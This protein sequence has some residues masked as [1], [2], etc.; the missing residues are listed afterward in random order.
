MNE[1]INR[2]KD[3]LRMLRTEKNMTI[4]ELATSL[5]LKR[6]TLN[7]YETGLREPDMD[8]IISIARFFDVS[9]D[10]LTGAA[11]NP[12]GKIVNGE[13]HGH[14]I[15]AE[16]DERVYPNGWSKE[17]IFEMVEKLEKLGIKID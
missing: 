10:F 17:K 5:G 1:K 12:H 7:N 11:E 14:E 8:T 13:Y 15:E 16:V 4:A 3:R 2:F 9:L 6:T